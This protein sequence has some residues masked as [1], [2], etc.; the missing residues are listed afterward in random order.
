MR[1]AGGMTNDY[2]ANNGLKNGNP[3]L[4]ANPAIYAQV[5]ALLGPDAIADIKQAAR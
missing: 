2:L 1:E 5:N 4:L 3:V